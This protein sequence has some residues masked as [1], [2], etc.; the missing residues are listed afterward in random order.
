MSKRGVML[1]ALTIAAS[2]AGSAELQS[3]QVAVGSIRTADHTTFHL[4][5]ATLE[6]VFLHLTGRSLRD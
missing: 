3:I 2:F 1:L 5:R 6:Q 4:E